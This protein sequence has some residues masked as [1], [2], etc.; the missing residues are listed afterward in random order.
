VRANLLRINVLRHVVTAGAA[1][2]ALAAGLSAQ[3]QTPPP[4]ELARRIQSRYEGIKDFSAS[5]E[6]K[7]A[8]GALKKQSVERGTVQ[9][10]KPGRM[11]WEYVEPERKLFVSDGRRLYAHVPADKQVIVSAVPGDDQATTPVLFLAGKG[12]LTRDFTVAS[13]SVAGAPAGTVAI[14]LVP[15]RREQEY[16]WLALVVD[17]QSLALRMLVA[18]DSQGGTSSFT[19]SNMKENVGLADSL[20]TFRIPRGT[21]VITRE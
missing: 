1:A 10:K 21:D 17:A 15:R 3:P 8:G 12:N 2:V 19:F 16:D 9:V 6:Q 14:K 18:G 7:Y 11:R 5:F 13:T 20:F 4:D